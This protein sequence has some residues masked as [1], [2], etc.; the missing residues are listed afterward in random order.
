[1]LLQVSFH[2]GISK[3]KYRADLKGAEVRIMRNYA[4]IGALGVLD[5]AQGGNPNGGSEFAHAA[6]KRFEFHQRAELLEGDLVFR[7][8]DRA[9]KGFVLRGR[10]AWSVGLKI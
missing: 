6:L 4:K 3:A 7:S 8:G 9:V 2:R 1:M 5:F 10:D